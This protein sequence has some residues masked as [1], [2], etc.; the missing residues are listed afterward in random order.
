MTYGLNTNN[1]T[2]VTLNGTTHAVSLYTGTAQPQAVLWG[3][4]NLS[5]DRE[6]TVVVN[7]PFGSPIN[8]DAFMY[9]PILHSTTVFVSIPFRIEQFVAPAA[10]VL[11]RR[12]EEQ[13]NT[14]SK[15]GDNSSGL[16][17]GLT[18]SAFVV[19][20]LFAFLICYIHRSRH[21]TNGNS[22]GS[23]S[24]SD[25]STILPFISP[26]GGNAT[27][28][29]SHNSPPQAAIPWEADYQA[30]GRD[31]VLDLGSGFA[32][33][34]RWRQRVS[35]AMFSGS[36]SAASNRR[37]AF[38]GTLMSESNFSSGEPGSPTSLLSPSGMT[39]STHFYAPS[40][41]PSVGRWA[42]RD[43]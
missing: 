34:S 39:L 1:S 35:R 36:R 21:S 25:S 6:H 24:R 2:T 41:M 12:S 16:I 4:S 18:I 7:N 22:L 38:S 20:M 27:T 13:S 9:E 23:K 33:R 43:G 30:E 26:P 37:S 15:G 40:T 11:S 32:S 14:D 28:H 31:R 3:Q 10:K 29:S 17:A 19:G 8:V 5:A 42:T